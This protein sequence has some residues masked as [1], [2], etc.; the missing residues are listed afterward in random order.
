MASPTPESLALAEAALLKIAQEFMADKRRVIC[1]HCKET[2]IYYL[3]DDNPK[4]G[5]LMRRTDFK[6]LDGTTPE[7]GDRI[8]CGACERGIRFWPEDIVDD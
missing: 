6:L 4:A 1:R 7:Q 5:D 2:A 3:P 8:A